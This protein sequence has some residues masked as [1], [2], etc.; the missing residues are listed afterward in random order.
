MSLF[1][2]QN[3]I[4]SKSKGIG[5]IPGFL[6]CEKKALWLAK[7]IKKGSYAEGR[8]DKSLIQM[9]EPSLATG[10]SKGLRPRL[11]RRLSGLN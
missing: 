2:S 1:M 7:F 11:N 3:A 9:P 6:T 5:S 8:R 10:G 4:L